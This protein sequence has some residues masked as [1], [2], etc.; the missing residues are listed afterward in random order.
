MRHSEREG[1]GASS[2]GEERRFAYEAREA[3]HLGGGN[4]KSPAGD[5]SRRFDR[6]STRDSRGGIHREKNARLERTGSNQGHDADEA[7]EEH[8]SIADR[9]SVPFLR[10]HFRGRPRGYER[11]EAGDG[12]ARD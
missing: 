1:R 7:L 4:R 2:A 9:P 6:A 5:R 10:N 8:R 12:A 3:V 11:M